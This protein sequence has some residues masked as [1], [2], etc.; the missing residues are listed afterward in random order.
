[1]SRRGLRSHTL[2]NVEKK[3]KLGNLLLSGFVAVSLGLVAVGCNENPVT[4]GTTG[5]APLPVSKVGANSLTPTSVA[6]QWTAPV[7]SGT[8]TYRVAWLGDAAADSGSATTSATTYTA[9]GLSSGK[10]YTFSV[11]AVRSGVS[12]T[13]TTV[14]WAGAQRYGGTTSLRVYETASSNPSGFTIDAAGSPAAVSVKTGNPGSVQLALYTT[15]TG[16]NFIIG[17][18][19]SIVEYKNSDNFD[20]NTFISD[21]IYAASSMDAWYSSSSIDTHIPTDGN[22]RAF[23]RADNTTLGEGFYVRTGVSGS[24]HYARV[25]IQNVGGALLQGTSP[26]RYVDLVISYQNTPNLPYAKRVAGYP[27]TPGVAAS[28][29]ASN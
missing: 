19:F 1:M 18:G 23:T 13:V 12:S 9:T 6:L 4:P 29:R 21:S 3:M 10:A 25:F 17:T 22:L 5:N 15:G 28:H 2:M 14:R 27:E 26:N 11:Y 24:Y 20:Q 16:S 7:D 8:I